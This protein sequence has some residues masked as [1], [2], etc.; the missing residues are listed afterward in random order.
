MSTNKDW[1]NRFIFLIK[2]TSDFSN[3]HPLSKYWQ[4]S[5][6]SIDLTFRGTEESHGTGTVERINYSSRNTLKAETMGRW[7]IHC[8]SVVYWTCYQWLSEGVVLSAASHSTVLFNSVRLPEACI[9]V[10][11]QV[12][13]LYTTIPVK[14][15]QWLQN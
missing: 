11:G 10:N 3:L 15:K 9:F 12:F 8:A 4:K 2:Y 7:L 1:L 6:Q 5:D 14:T 13:T